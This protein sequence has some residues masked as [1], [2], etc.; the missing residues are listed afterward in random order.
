MCHEFGRLVI[1]ANNFY[2]QLLHHFLAAEVLQHACWRVLFQSIAIDCVEVQNTTLL[3]I[4]EDVE[5]SEFGEHLRD[6]RCSHLGNIKICPELNPNVVLV[7]GFALN[8]HLI[9]LGRIKMVA[10]A[11]VPLIEHHQVQMLPRELMI[12]INWFV[13]VAVGINVAAL[14]LLLNFIGLFGILL[15]II[16]RLFVLF[17]F[18]WAALL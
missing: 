13:L 15:L 4:F 14:L 2:L 17:I 10:G 16:L 11:P 12:P 6:G 9:L 18:S 5:I 3:G 8:L 7:L 1:R